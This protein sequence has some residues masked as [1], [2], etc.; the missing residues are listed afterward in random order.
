LT[1]AITDKKLSRRQFVG[2]AAGGAAA[3]G[4]GAILAPTLASAAGATPAAPATR[5]QAVA[6]KP[7]ASAPATAQS[8]AIPQS[9]DYTADVVVVGSG[10]AGM[11]AALAA[12]EA[13][14]SVLVVE[15]NYDVGGH[16]ITSGGMVD[17]GA[18]NSAQVAYGIVDSVQLVFS[19][20]TTPAAMN[21]NSYGTKYQD[22]AMCWTEANNNVAIFNW[23]LANGVQYTDTAVA[24]TPPDTSHWNP[25]SGTARTQHMY[26][27]GASSF[28][29]SAASPAGG[30]GT[31]LIRPLEATA[32]AKGVQFLL[33][34]R[35]TSVIREAPYSG[36]A[37]GITAVFTGGRFLPGSITPLLP[38]ATQGNISLE[39]TT[40]SIRANK[41]VVLATGGSSSNVAWR[42]LYDMRQTAVYSVGGEPY[43]YQTADGEYAAQRVGAKLWAT[44]NETSENGA[45]LAKPGYI[46][47]RYG[48][49][50]I[51]WVP[52]SPVFALAG[53]GGL[54]VSNWGDVLQVNM[55]GVRFVDESAS[56]YVWLDACMAINAASVAPDWAAGPIW[57][58][59]D[60]AAVTRENWTLGAPNTD[61]LWFY[62]ASTLPALAQQISTNAY[63]ATPMNGA[64]LQA[65]VTRYNTLAAAGKDLD[66]G[67]ASIKYQINTPP[68]YAA[69]SAP[70][71]HDS[72]AGIH[73]NTNG[74]VMDLDDNV[75]PK[76]YAAG[77]TVGG[78]AM[79]GLAKCLI[80]GRIAGTNAGAETPYLT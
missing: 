80:F 61:P 58:I 6:V 66:F 48:Y 54:S 15:M 9:W 49:G 52:A 50:S 26:W 20:L 71:I 13:G 29:A 53:A 42:R 39:N 17:V 76:L 79:H 37:I 7:L 74:Q 3:L 40:V 4:A 22:R 68:Y 1:D 41:A 77:E 19:D 27:N 10:A 45:E 55:A 31:G 64:T 72:L 69:F 16:A 70:S 12:Y 30:G 28:P 65:T 18:G 60:S 67:K 51:H 24:N 63:Q 44:G 2:A 34:Y 11:A 43:S 73:I 33:N 36:N 25:V 8:G 62:E 57:T 46:G 47:C 38:Y 21:L 32:R 14:A 35:M 75:I 78:F 23:L 56:S 59:F 5:A